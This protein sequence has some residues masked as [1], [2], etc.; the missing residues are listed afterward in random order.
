MDNWVKQA[1]KGL[2]DYVLLRCISERPVYAFEI[3]QR[4]EQMGFDVSAGTVYPALSRLRA[5]RWVTVRMEE[6][7]LGAPRKY[8]SIT[9]LGKARMAAM[10]ELLKPMVT[11]LN[12]LLVGEQ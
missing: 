6:S 5:E 1:R 8:Y 12:T 11:S 4:V 3:A 2:L 7:K 10:A 9:P